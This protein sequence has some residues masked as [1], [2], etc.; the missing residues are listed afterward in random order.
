M[1]NN[2]WLKEIVYGVVSAQKVINRAVA[3]MN[4]DP[5][6]ERGRFMYD[7]LNE[8]IRISWYKLYAK[9]SNYMRHLPKEEFDKVFG[10]EV[11]VEELRL[12][13]EFDR[14]MTFLSNRAKEHK[15][16]DCGKCKED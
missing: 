6:K 14:G 11:T 2:D 4:D 7:V 3:T 8:N 5:N 16:S 15:E 1:Q 12:F 9:A 10:D 13:G